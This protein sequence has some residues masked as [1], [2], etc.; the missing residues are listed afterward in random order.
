MEASD[1]RVI[2]VIM[3]F[4]ANPVS[5]HEARHQKYMED[6]KSFV[7]QQSQPPLQKP[8]EAYGKPREAEYVPSYQTKY[9][10]GPQPETVQR[11]YLPSEASPGRAVRKKHAY[12]EPAEEYYPFGKPGAGA[13]LKN[14]D[15]EYAC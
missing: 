11:A 9:D 13:P 7:K 1:S 15:D 2:F 12:E 14:H 10:R 4:L 5:E 8:T 3:S 6:F